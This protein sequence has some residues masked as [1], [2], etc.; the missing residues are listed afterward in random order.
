MTGLPVRLQRSPLIEALF[1]IR[2]EPSSPSARDLLVGSVYPKVRDWTPV[3]EQLPFASIPKALREQ[4]EKLRYQASH[5]L[6]SSTGSEYIVLGEQVAGV[7]T[8]SYRGW[9]DFLSKIERLTSALQGTDLVG[10]VTRVS[11]RY[12]NVLQIPIG[13]RLSKLNVKI[14]ERG[15][16]PD[17]RGMHLRYEIHHSE[18]CLSIVQIAP[19]ATA[20]TVKGPIEGLLVD[21]DTI[22][23]KRPGLGELKPH[24][25]M[26]HSRSKEVFFTLLTD[27]TIEELGPVPK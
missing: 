16:Q 22:G 10:K 7:S 11:I 26:L 23:D 19:T 2:F 5:R 20:A 6:K 21:V 3:V 8:Q 18:G 27:E 1:E 9:T 17:E 14:V 25:E 24:V 13:S 4:D 15:N 12:I